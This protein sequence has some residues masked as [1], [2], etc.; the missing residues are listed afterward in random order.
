MRTLPQVPL[1]VPDPLRPFLS[2]KEI[3]D[4]FGRDMLEDPDMLEDFRKLDRAM[5]K[6]EALRVRGKQG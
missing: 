5:E 3:T 4:I 1:C 6:R 2:R